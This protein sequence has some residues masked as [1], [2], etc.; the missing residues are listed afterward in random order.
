VGTN[1]KWI[2]NARRILERPIRNDADEA[3][4][5]GL[6]GEFHLALGGSLREAARMADAACAAPA[7]RATLV[8]TRSSSHCTTIAFDVHRSRRQHL[9]RLARALELPPIDLRGRPATSWRTIQAR[10]E[11]RLARRDDEYKLRANAMHGTPRERLAE[12]GAIAGLLDDLVA[13]RVRF[14]LAGEAAAFL[15]GALSMPTALDILYD[16]REPQALRTLAM[17]LCTWRAAPRGLEREVDEIDEHDLR[18]VPTLALAVRGLPMNLWGRLDTT[19]AFSD[20]RTHQDDR[21]AFASLPFPVLGLP[22]L[23]SECSAGRAARH[24]EMRF[25]LGILELVR[26]Q[27]LR[28]DAA[29]ARL[30]NFPRARQNA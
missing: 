22:A 3:R 26:Q 27:R 4:W 5:L 20:A 11:H 1:H 14:L 7:D 30:P 13:S 8:L 21:A 28:A 9:L 10:I 2:Q 17:Q 19:G 16:G 12:L 24:R 25:Q 6:V 18:A 29:R 15:Q 23:I